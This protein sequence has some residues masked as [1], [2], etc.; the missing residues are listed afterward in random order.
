[1]MKQML[2]KNLLLCINV[3]SKNI[4][5]VFL[6][7]FK[8]TSQVFKVFSRSI[9]STCVKRTAA[10]AG[11]FEKDEYSKVICNNGK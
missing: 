3:G 2:W 6:L 11:G 8:M 4:F 1:M 7:I 10:G 5:T 9:H